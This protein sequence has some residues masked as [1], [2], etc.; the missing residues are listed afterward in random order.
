MGTAAFV[1]ENVTGGPEGTSSCSRRVASMP[2]QPLS[3]QAPCIWTGAT[4]PH[5]AALPHPRPGREGTTKIL[6]STDVLSRGFD[7]TQVSA[8]RADRWGRG[9]GMPSRASCADAEC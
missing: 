3:S 5:H 4:Q 1:S 6:I 2:A 8:G 7:V 9:S